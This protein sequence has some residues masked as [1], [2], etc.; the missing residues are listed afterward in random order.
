M[1]GLAPAVVHG[2]GAPGDIDNNVSFGRLRKVIGTLST[3]GEDV[4]HSA[5]ELLEREYRSTNCCQISFILRVVAH[6]TS[7][8]FTMCR[9]K[10]KG[11]HPDPD[12]GFPLK[13]KL[14]HLCTLC[15]KSDSIS[16]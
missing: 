4:L 12:W 10:V 1:M 8:S 3:Q 14:S 6:F 9:A 2:P 15:Q 5:E 11:A 7:C 16:Y 13:K